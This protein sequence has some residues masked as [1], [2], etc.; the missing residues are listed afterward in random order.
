MTTLFI[1]DLH[2][3]EERPEIARAL[4]NLLADPGKNVEALYILGDFFE[5]W[6][7]DDGIT[8]FQDKIAHAVKKFSETFA[9]VYFMHGN[10]DLLIGNQFAHQA[11]CTIL[12]DPCIIDLYGEPTL[13][14][15]GDSLCTLDVAY[16]RFRRATRNPIIRWLLLK[17]PLSYRISSIRKLRSNS[18]KQGPM[19]SRDIM[20]VTSDEVIKTMEKHNCQRLIHG[21]TH[22]PDRH[23]ITVNGKPAERIVLGDWEKQGWILRSD[24]KSLEL[25]SFPINQ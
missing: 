23:T 4:L 5:Y 12:K 10:R 22:R 8:P 1:S 21:H 13:L 19:K 7:G 14:M 11:G 2:L 25:K 3:Q 24:D 20:D 18:A 16:Q 9:P 6:V 15:H 17:L